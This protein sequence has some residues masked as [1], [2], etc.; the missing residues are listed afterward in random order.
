AQFEVVD[1]RFNEMDAQFEVVDR[2]FNE[3]DAQFEVVD[4]RFNEMDAQFEVV[5]K[6]FVDIENGFANIH[7][8]FIKINKK[9][10]QH[11]FNYKDFISSTE[12]MGSTIANNYSEQKFEL[13]FLN[14]R[15]DKIEKQIFKIESKQ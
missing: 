15:V 2:R 7:N 11:D 5:D 3:M 12:E 4:R 14:A 10:D 1:R 13:N 9:F 8:E 6:R